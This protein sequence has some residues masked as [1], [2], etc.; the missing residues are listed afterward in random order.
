[1]GVS[2]HKLRKLTDT[3]LLKYLKSDAPYTVKAVEM[4]KSILENERQ[5]VFSE[6]EIISINQIILQ[7][8]AAEL[9]AVQEY[10]QDYIMPDTLENAHYPKLHS[11]KYVMTV[12]GFFI[13]AAGHC[14][15]ENLDELGLMNK[16]LKTKIITLSTV[17]VLVLI[18]LLLAY[19]FFGYD[20]MLVYEQ[21]NHRNYGRYRLT[22]NNV[23]IFIFFIVNGLFSYA[24]WK[25]FMP[26]KTKYR[27]KVDPP[28]S[29]F[30]W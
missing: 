1:M 12:G 7:K 25:Y 17:G 13:G 23:F 8:K 5:Y 10:N 3:Q 6:Q 30:Y 28:S 29:T 24:I 18:T 14:V 21:N 22:A 11:L 9:E 26:E 19:Y 20:L 4:A 2:I 27:A 15:Y 16:S